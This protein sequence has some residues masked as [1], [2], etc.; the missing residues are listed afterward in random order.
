MSLPQYPFKGQQF[1]VRPGINMHYLDEGPRDADPVVMVHGNPSWSYYYRRLVSALSGTD[2]GP[3]YRC[4]VPDHVGMG[5][6]DKPTDAE[7][8][9]TLES[10]I[11]DLDALLNHL[12]V[13]QKVTLVVHD[14]GGMIGF[15]WA[16]RHPDIVR[17]L[18]IL[19]TAAFPLPEGK[20]LPWQLN[21]VRNTRLGA[22]MVR[23]FNAFA[24]GAATQGVMRKMPADERRALL[25]PYNSWH[26]RIGTLRF[27][28]DIPLKAGDPG[29]DIVANSAQHLHQFADRP[30]IA[31]W[32]LKDFVF[33]KDFLDGFRQRLPQLDVHAWDDA[34]HYVLEDAHERIIPLVQDFLTR[35]PLDATA[36]TP[37]AA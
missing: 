33:D 8:S 12:E 2:A 28:Q 15:G 27:V 17:R 10:R 24:Y 25:S 31:C 19:N 3:C 14:W 29:Y 13:N 22:F 20:P 4:I 9:Y 7:Y 6:S 16:M 11:D 30:A 1:A 21:L 37:P 18:V 32:G 5:L 36:N 35:H 34:G 23:G 26:N